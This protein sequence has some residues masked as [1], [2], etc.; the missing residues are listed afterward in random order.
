MVSDRNS[1]IISAFFLLS[2]VEYLLV[3]GGHT[4]F[5]YVFVL[6]LIFQFVCIISMDCRPIY[7]V[8]IT[9]LFILNFSSIFV[10]PQFGLYGWDSP[11]TYYLTA[12]LMSGKPP[13]QVIGTPLL[14]ILSI[15]VNE[16]IAVDIEVIL[17]YLPLGLSAGIYMAVFLIIK[18][19]SNSRMAVFGILSLGSLW[20]F[21]SFHTWAVKEALGFPLLL[22][23]IYILGYSNFRNWKI[24]MISMFL[25]PALAF[26]HHLSTLLLVLFICCSIFVRLLDREEQIN[27]PRYISILVIIS[28]IWTYI[29]VTPLL[30]GVYLAK[31]ARQTILSLFFGTS[32]TAG[33]SS[34]S[35]QATAINPIQTIFQFQN[36]ISMLKILW[37]GGVMHAPW[38]SGIKLSV[39]FIG[40]CLLFHLVI[41]VLTKKK[42]IV[43]QSTY[44]A[45]LLSLVALFTLSL[46]ADGIGGRRV[47]EISW[48]FSIP[49][50]V[51][52]SKSLCTEEYVKYALTVF[53]LL[54][55]LTFPVH[56][57]STTHAPDY[58]GGEQ[59]FGYEKSDYTVRS[60]SGD[61][62]SGK[63]T[64]DIKYV[65]FWRADVNLESYSGGEYMDL[66]L[67]TNEDVYLFV[68]PSSQSMLL[69]SQGY[70]RSPPQYSAKTNLANIYSSGSVSDPEK[71]IYYYSSD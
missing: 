33:T 67:T 63:I 26:S 28:S 61:H 50:L 51:S 47:I 54:N 23:C 68:S 4:P 41:V 43:H 58:Y 56:V 25:V 55:I 3:S 11:Q 2:S 46:F 10:V 40:V 39:L 32:V 12:Q 29:V 38:F 49:L 1:I 24:Q 6:C 48:V 18:K 45:C 65:R 70:T 7:R 20:F 21:V 9:F 14:H 64:S 66:N 57:F 16:I 60:W 19:L 22:I 27:F 59:D 30:S 62:L 52:F 13:F 5:P 8:I 31:T 37:R 17:K 34:S 35:T 36:D 69:T 15:L 53:V 71:N 42:I 44:F